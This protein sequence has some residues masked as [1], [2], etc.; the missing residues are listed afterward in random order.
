MFH[1]HLS[2]SVTVWVLCHWLNFTWLIIV[3]LIICNSTLETIPILVFA[4]LIHRHGNL[5]LKFFLW[6]FNV[7]YTYRST[8]CSNFSSFYFSG[9]CS[10]LLCFN[11]IIIYMFTIS[12]FN[13]SYIFAV[14]FKITITLPD[15]L[16]LFNSSFSLD[17]KTFLTL[18]KWT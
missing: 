16:T 7:T 3:L 6:S 2:I 17:W 11:N 1:I 5:V 4:E 9:H 15:S 12:F 8:Y 14:F 10:F 13:I 18:R